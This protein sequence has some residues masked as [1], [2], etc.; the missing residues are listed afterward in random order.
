MPTIEATV[1]SLFPNDADVYW[2]ASI[3]DDPPGT[4]GGGPVTYTESAA[5][6]ES[7]TSYSPVFGSIL[8][9]NLVV[10]ASCAAPGYAVYTTT[11]QEQIKGTQPTKTTILSYIGT[12][13]SPFDAG[14]LVRIGCYESA[15]LN[16]FDSSGLPFYGGGGDAGIMQICFQRT[17]ADIWNWKANI[18]SGRV[19]LLGTVSPAKSHLDHEVNVEGATP[20]PTSFW[21]EESIH[22]FNAGTGTGNEYREWDSSLGAWV[23]VDR[24]GAGNYVPHILS[25]SSQCT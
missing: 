5:S 23:I 17:Q 11:Q 6:G 15:G 7:P 1:T 2:A 4:C 10:V 19:N 9:G 21:R 3:T 8:G 18:D 20:Y 22:R 12:M 16:Q 25:Q 13:S 24:G 14:D